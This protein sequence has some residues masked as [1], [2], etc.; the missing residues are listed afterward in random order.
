MVRYF[1]M[2]GSRIAEENCT[3]PPP[4]PDW[5]VLLLPQPRQQPDSGYRL[6]AA[7]RFRHGSLFLTAKAHLGSC[8]DQSRFGTLC[9]S[10]SV[11]PTTAAGLRL[12]R[13]LVLVMF[14]KHP[15]T[16][17][18]AGYRPDRNTTTRSSITSNTNFCSDE[19]ETM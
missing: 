12:V 10:R 18:T 16:Y 8:F 11:T 13:L 6:L 1:S 14:Y 19:F 7:C 15:S 4:C 9:A 3:R 2:H 5:C 17:S